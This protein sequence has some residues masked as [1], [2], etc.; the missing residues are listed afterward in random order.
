MRIRKLNHSIYQVQYHVVWITKY[1][2]KILKQY[3]KKELI[4]GIYKVLRRH[5]EWYMKKINVGKEDHIHIQIE[6]PPKERVSDV[7]REIKSCTSSDLKKRFKFIEKIYGKGGM[8]SVGYF[9]STIGL[10]EEQVSKYIEYQSKEDKGE[11]V[12]SEFS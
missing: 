10:N 2:R 11:D 8:W 9:V 4:K 5:P 6:I 3:V 1:R 7:I 12:T